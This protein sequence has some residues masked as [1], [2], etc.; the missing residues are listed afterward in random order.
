MKTFAVIKNN[1]ITNLVVSDDA[2]AESILSLLI[3]DADRIQNCEE[4]PNAYIGGKIENGKVI[5]LQPFPSWLWS[6]DEFNWI[7]PVAKPG[8]DF[9][10]HEPDGWVQ[11]PS[12]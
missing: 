12:P 4:L 8:E 10:W 3:P 7:P 2:D 6:E 1:I 11:A 9:F 5:P